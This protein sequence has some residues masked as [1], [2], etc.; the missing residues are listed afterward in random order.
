MPSTIG[1]A[2][3][4]AVYK[5]RLRQRDA[6]AEELN[7][8][9]QVANTGAAG[10]LQA[11]LRAYESISQG[12]IVNASASIDAAYTDPSVTIGTA[13]MFPKIGDLMVLVFTR[14][15]PDV[16]SRIVTREFAVLAPHPDT[17]DTA[18]KKPVMVRGVT[19]ADAAGR[20]EAL[21]ALVDW[22]EDSLITEVGD[23]ITVGGFTYNETE[24]R[25]ISIPK[26]Y[27]GNPV[28]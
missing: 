25:L 2:T 27:D 19:F 28:S 1:L 8:H 23:E 10:N 6:L 26:T 3:L 15:H 13:G 21:G 4:N 11:A 22:L 14:A 12:G 17:Y 24:S 5:V 20:T 9:F 7:K 16:P 18:T